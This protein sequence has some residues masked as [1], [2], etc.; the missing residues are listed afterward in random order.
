MA[1]HEQET[2]PR[3]NGV[4]WQ[5]WL[6]EYGARLYAYANGLDSTEAD[7][8]VQHAL[9]GAVKAVREGRLRPQGDD[10]LRY[11][12]VSVRHAAYRHF[13]KRHRRSAVEGAWS[14]EKP[15]LG[16]VA[17]K[18]EQCRSV[19]AAMRTLPPAH[20]EVVFLHLWGG[21]TF[22]DIADTLGE[23]LASVTSRYRYAIT[24][25]RKQIQNP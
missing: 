17:E 16:G 10:I 11:A 5:A 2:S 19:E 14:A 3:A 18:E 25:I 8:L 1:T 21:Q 6:D 4:D 15:W 22:Q 20:A 23:S 24:L 13:S 12:Y 7:D 9:L